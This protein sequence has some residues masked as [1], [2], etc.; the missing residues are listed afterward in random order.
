VYHE[1]TTD[2]ITLVPAKYGGGNN[3]IEQSPDFSSIMLLPF[4]IIDV[5]C[6]RGF[7]IQPIE[8]V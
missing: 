4:R 1:K 3:F 5:G 2:Q 6:I 8:F 7:Q